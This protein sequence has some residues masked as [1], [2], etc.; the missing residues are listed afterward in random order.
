MEKD[1]TKDCMEGSHQVDTRSPGA[2][3]PGPAPGTRVG[4][5]WPPSRCLFAYLKPIDLKLPRTEKFST[6]QRHSRRHLETL[7]GGFWS[8]VSA[9]CWGG[10]HRRRHLHHHDCLS[11]DV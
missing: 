2:V 4:P 6:K 8:P 10:N 1:V 7:F 3:P 9:P 5:T 11:D